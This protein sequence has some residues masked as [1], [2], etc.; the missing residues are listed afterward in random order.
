MHAG[1]HAHSVSPFPPAHGRCRA[2]VCSAPERALSFVKRKPSQGLLLCLSRRVHHHGRFSDIRLLVDLQVCCAKVEAAEQNYL[3]VVRAGG[4]RQGRAG[5]VPCTVLIQA[6][7]A[8]LCVRAHVRVCARGVRVRVSRAALSSVDTGKRIVPRS[9]PSRTLRTAPT[10]S[11]MSSP[12][13]RCLFAAGR[14][15]ALTRGDF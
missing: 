13:P 4:S 2:L 5:C 7:D 15:A 6:A 11:R 3:K 8:S 14:F 10:I 12:R 9:K 1:S